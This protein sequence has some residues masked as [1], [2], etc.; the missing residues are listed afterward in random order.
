MTPPG[1]VLDAVRFDYEDMHMLFSAA[2]PAGAFLGVIGP[3]GAGKS[4]L[5]NLI[6]GFEVPLSGRILMEGVDYTDAPPQ[7]RPVTMLFQE[8]NLFFHLDVYTNVALGISPSLRLREEDRAALAA[9]LARVGLSGMERRLPRELSGGERQRAAIARALVRRRPILLLDEPFA[10]LGPALRHDMLQ[11]VR[12]LS[13]ERGLTV[14]FVTHNPGDAERAATHTAFVEGGRII[15]LR[16][17]AEFFAARDLPGLAD[18]LG[19]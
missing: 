5:L 10:A 7:E 16:P 9:A 19:E 14:M 13:D 18:Y 12:E 1:I 17:T 15:A 8:N 3:S 2:V 4:S 11:L 6:A